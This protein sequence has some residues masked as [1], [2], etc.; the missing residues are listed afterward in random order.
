MLIIYDVEDRRPGAGKAGFPAV[1]ARQLMTWH[2]NVAYLIQC[3]DKW[4]F[5]TSEE[6]DRLAC[7]RFKT[8]H[9]VDDKN[10]KITQR[11]TTTT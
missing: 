2:S 1:K 8:M 5:P 11:R 3:N 9:D 6:L 4:R 10:R 7:L